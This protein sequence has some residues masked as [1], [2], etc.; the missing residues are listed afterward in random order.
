MTSVIVYL[1]NKGFRHLYQNCLHINYML[2]KILLTFC[3]CY[4]EIYKLLRTSN[5]FW[6]ADID[7]C[8]DPELQEGDNCSEGCVNTLGSYKCVNLK[9][10]TPA[11]L[12]PTSTEHINPVSTKITLCSPGFEIG[13]SGS[14]M[15]IDE[16]A[17]NNG[18]CSHT[19]QNTL[20]GANCICPTGFM[21]GNDWKSCKGTQF[22]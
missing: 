12:S 1:T 4:P 3:C 22:S 18:G 8:S 21:L 11:E 6:F 20:G 14:C 17:I 16:C 9:D 15:D 10:L 19:C 7:E 5:F 2:K 13:P